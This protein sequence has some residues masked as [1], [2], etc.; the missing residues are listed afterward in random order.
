MD[1]QTFIEYL[2]VKQAIDDRSLNRAVWETLVTAMPPASPEQPWQVLEVGAGIGTMI[3]RLVEWDF[4]HDARYT[5]LDASKTFLEEGSRRLS[6]WASRRGLDLLK[7]EESLQV[8]DASHAIQVD[9]VAQELGQW[10]KE[11]V[12][13][14]TYDLLIAH[15]FL[16]LVNLE[17]TLPHLM[18]CLK[19][20][21]LFY[22]TINFDG[23]TVFE[24]PVDE[25]LDERV[26]SLYHRTMEERLAGEKRSAGA[27]SGR[28]LL[29]VLEQA[30]GTL[31]CAG[32][33]DWVIHPV[34]GKYPMGEDR[35]LRFFL[36]MIGEALSG[37]KELRED[38]LQN[39]LA[40]R[41]HQI[42]SH[43]LTLIV[44]QLDLVGRRLR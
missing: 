2:R 44:H 28:R 19:K 18:S 16:D 4:L 27:Y 17:E 26:L 13:R 24:P 12:C 6:Q 41:L 5:A 9:F 23:L 36:Q 30:G 21:G 34:E 7:D 8:S 20:G 15:A 22:F 38:E 10:L 33:S 32:A 29:R 37:R 39:W 11:A 35:F 42:E 31:L 3:Q 40:Q 43:S 14:E 1:E 25:D